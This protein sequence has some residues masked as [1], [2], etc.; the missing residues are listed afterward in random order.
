[1]PGAFPEPT[2]QGLRHLTIN[3]R[4]DMRELIQSETEAVNGAGFLRD[5]T[6]DLRYA[7]NMLPT[8]YDEAIT[9]TTDMMCR[10]T[11]NC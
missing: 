2:A 4:A 10:Y 9:S 5:F 6:N 8:I 7:I 3:R 1:M 11:G